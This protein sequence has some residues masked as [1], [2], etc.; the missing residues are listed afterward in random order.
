MVDLS[1]SIISTLLF[2][3]NFY[4]LFNRNNYFAE[5]SEQI[6]LLHT[7]SLSVEE[8]FY[9]FFPFILLIVLKYYKKNLSLFLLIGI[10]LSFTLSVILSKSA[11]PEIISYPTCSFF[12]V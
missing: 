9:I 10:F 6:P 11:K 7:W 4:F 8:Q 1:R 3:S 2:L 5:S 12:S